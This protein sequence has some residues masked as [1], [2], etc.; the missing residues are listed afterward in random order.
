MEVNLMFRFML[1]I[2]LTLA[3]AYFASLEMA[4]V[5][6]NKNKIHQM[7]E[8]EN[9]KQAIR[10]MKMFG[11]PGMILST[12]QIGVT[13]TGLLNSAFAATGL[14]GIMA[15]F[16]GKYKI[17]YSQQL[18]VIIITVLLSYFVLVFGELVPKRI[19]LQNSESWAL[20][21]SGSVV[22]FSKL[23]APF[24]KLLSA[25]T[26]CILKI[27]GYNKVAEE[28]ISESEIK[29]LIEKG[30]EQGN[31]EEFEEQML[32]HVF[33]FKEKTAEEIM[34]RAEKIY[35][36]SYESTLGELL[37]TLPEQ[38]FSR[39]P[40]YKNDEDHIVGICYIK[41]V[42]ANSMKKN[43]KNICEKD[44]MRKPFMAHKEIQINKLF[45]IMQKNRK[46][47]A[48]LTDNRARFKGIITIED[49]IEEIMGDI[50]DEYDIESM[51]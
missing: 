36:V 4:F 28:E 30:K 47:M 6:S 42:L 17:P 22:L 24:V 50:I 51:G 1:I 11:D 8:E 15:D 31:I 14:S 16:L 3:K 12:I 38:L 33:D 25:T 20:F 27:T 43:Y 35:S 45:L 21:T 48:V 44:I 34:I 9:D 39:I 40:V 41:D 46:H 19:A 29:F 5:S 10:L 26:D 23:G 7:A 18:G 49:L 32:L 13:L 2:L 37:E